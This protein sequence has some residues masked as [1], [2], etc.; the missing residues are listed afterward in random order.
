MAYRPVPQFPPIGERVTIAMTA[1]RPGRRTSD[2][3]KPFESTL[4]LSSRRD[5]PEGTGGIK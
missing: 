4:R 5:R 2:G 3:M 1:S